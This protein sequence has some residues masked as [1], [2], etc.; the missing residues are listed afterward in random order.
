MRP[1]PIGRVEEARTDRLAKHLAM[2]WSVRGYAIAVRDPLRTDSRPLRCSRISCA[3]RRSADHA[4]V[5]VILHLD[6]CDL[7]YE[8]FPIGVVRPAMDPGRYAELVNRFPPLDLFRN[9]DYM[10]KPGSKLTLSEKEDPRTYERFIR[11]DPLWREFHSY[12]KSDDF[13]FS[14]VDLLARHHIDLGLRRISPSRLRWKRL[15][16]ALEGRLATAAPRLATRFE[17]SALAASGGCVLPHTDAPNKLI[18]LVLSMV[19]PGEWNPSWGGGTDVNRPK[20]FRH[21]YNQM[22]E[23]ADFGDMEILHTYDFAP[24]QTL[25][26]VKTF[27]SW[28]SVRPIRGTASDPYRR[29][30]TINIERVG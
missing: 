20:D 2:G 6:H 11:A 4:E 9:Y 1:L 29:S 22:N 12:V 21:A 13:I 10:G 8:P 25:L 19:R 3:C 18:T 23:V 14:V 28:H 30:L 15:R 5:P 17:F 7:R 27:N 26:F 16:S 24:N